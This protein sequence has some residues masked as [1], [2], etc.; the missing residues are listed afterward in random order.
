MTTIKITSKNVAT[1]VGNFNLKH[2][3]TGEAKL[4]GRKEITPLHI[5]HHFKALS[6]TIIAG[7]IGEAIKASKLKM[8]ELIYK[9]AHK[10]FKDEWAERFTCNGC[11]WVYT[12]KLDRMKEYE[13]RTISREIL[14]Y[15]K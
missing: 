2:L 6:C 13:L 3:S 15:T 14:A 5:D 7:I 4:V 9:L 11:E 10:E 8:T 1:K 12:E